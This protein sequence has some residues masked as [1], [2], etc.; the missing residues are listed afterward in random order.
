[1]TARQDG[2]LATI[3]VALGLDLVAVLGGGEFGAALVRDDGG[4]E[5]VLKALPG[6]VWAARFARAPS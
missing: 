1:M 4:R 6:E 2:A 5:L 3:A